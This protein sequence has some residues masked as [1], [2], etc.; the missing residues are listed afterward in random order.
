MPE[1]RQIKINSDLHKRIKLAATMQETTIKEWVEGVLEDAL[2]GR[3][4][5]SVL[6]DTKGKYVVP[7]P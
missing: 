7:T 4:S 5:A 1:L 2:D 3:P 6:I